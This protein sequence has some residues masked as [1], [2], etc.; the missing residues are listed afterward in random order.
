MRESAGPRFKSKLP[1]A[2]AGRGRWGSGRGRR[3]AF[4]ACALG[5]GAALAL[6]RRASGVASVGRGA[7]GC[8]ESGLESLGPQDGVPGEAGPGGGR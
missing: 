4:C 5:V 2:E 8:R 1:T 3:R 6:P 7:S